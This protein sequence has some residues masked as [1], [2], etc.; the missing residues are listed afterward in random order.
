MNIQSPAVFV[1]SSIIKCQVPNGVG[2]APVTVNIVYDGTPIV[3]DKQ[4]SF[5]YLGILFIVT[6]CFLMYNLGNCASSSCYNGGLCSL[7]SC[8]CTPPYTGDNCA[9]TYPYPN[10]YP[11][12][13]PLTRILEG[14][15][16]QTH[17]LTI[18]ALPPYTISIFNSPEDA[19]FNYTSGK[20]TA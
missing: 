10:I 11:E 7:G 13:F 16:Y 14:T 8:L 17:E 15:F 9:S 19:T 5:V 1:N 4:S 2:T 3:N 6:I 20:I 18:D 12:I